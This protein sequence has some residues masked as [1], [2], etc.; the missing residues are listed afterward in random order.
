[1]NKRYSMIS[2]MICGLIFPSFSTANT[3]YFKGT[4]VEQTCKVN[5]Y[6]LQPTI[7]CLYG[8]LLTKRKL[9]SRGKYSFLQKNQYIS[10]VKI[11]SVNKEKKLALID[12]KYY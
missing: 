4:I 5:H 1:M 6:G 9:S 11:Y 7:T 2:V 8:G 3:L 10:G 12:V